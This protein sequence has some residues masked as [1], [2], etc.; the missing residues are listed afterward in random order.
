MTPHA[1]TL[2]LRQYE[3]NLLF[4]ITQILFLWI[5]TQRNQSSI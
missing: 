1:D 2:N 5:N 4:S 3:D